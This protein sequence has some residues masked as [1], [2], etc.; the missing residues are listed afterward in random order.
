MVDFQLPAQVWFPVVTLVVGAL[1]KGIF[2]MLSDRRSHRREREARYEQRRDALALRRAEFQ[3]ETLLKL[4]DVISQMTRLTGRINH[5]DVMAFRQSGAWRQN[6]LPEDV[7]QGYLEATMQMGQLRV[8]VRDDSIRELAA[9]FSSTCAGV[10]M[11]TSEDESRALID[12]I[13][14][15]RDQ[16]VER[17]GA[18]LRSLDDGEDQILADHR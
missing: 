14:S 13:V 8:R 6:R 3:R 17:L 4:Q 12:E 5:E 15:V 1:L 2:D 10:G 9:H 7:N 18:V 16:L 11:A